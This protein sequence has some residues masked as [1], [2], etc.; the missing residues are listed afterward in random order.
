MRTIICHL[1]AV[2]GLHFPFQKECAGVREYLKDN[3]EI[4]VGSSTQLLALD[5]ICQ[6]EGYRLEVHFPD[7]SVSTNEGENG[8]CAAHFYVTKEYIFIDVAG[9]NW[10]DDPRAADASGEA[11]NA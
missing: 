9:P 5:A 10:E 3:D 11:P 1:D 8:I 6:K 4:T 2:N 7:G